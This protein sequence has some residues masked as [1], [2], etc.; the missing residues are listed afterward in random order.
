M[1]SD[2]TETV[3][4]AYKLVFKSPH[5]EIVAEDLLRTYVL[6]SRE[7]DSLEARISKR[8]LVVEILTNANL[9]PIKKARSIMEEN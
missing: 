8:D 2:S 1:K 9:N 4:Q 6:S 5:G 3:N 7:G